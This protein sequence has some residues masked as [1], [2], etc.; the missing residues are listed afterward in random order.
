MYLA[1]VN[2]TCDWDESRGAVDPSTRAAADFLRGWG[3]LRLSRTPAAF[4]VPLS[5][6]FGEAGDV[7]KRWEVVGGCWP[8]T[9]FSRE[10]SGLAMQFVLRDVQHTPNG[11]SQL[12]GAE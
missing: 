3:E 12:A 11:H 7:Q 1:R 2:L 8:A 6:V 4:A 5:L 9:H 10:R